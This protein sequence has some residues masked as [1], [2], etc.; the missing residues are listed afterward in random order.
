MNRVK[1]LFILDFLADVVPWRSVFHLHPVTPLF[2]KSD[3][4][5][6]AQTY[7]G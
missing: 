7:F 5:K 1:T 3:N 6:L 4:S 2:F